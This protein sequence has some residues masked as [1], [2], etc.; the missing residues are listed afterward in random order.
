MILAVAFFA[1][2]VN[3]QTAPAKQE[4]PKKEEKKEM[5]KEEKKEMKKEKRQKKREE[6]LAKA[7]K[8]WDMDDEPGG[9]DIGF[10]GL[11]SYGKFQKKSFGGLFSK[12]K[13]S[14]A[15][16]SSLQ[17]QGD[18]PYASEDRKMS[19]PKSPRIDPAVATISRLEGEIK[20][21][22]GE[23]QK[24]EAVTNTEIA[25]LTTELAGLDGKKETLKET[26]DLAISATVPPQVKDPSGSVELVDY[27]K[28][29]GMLDQKF[30]KLDEDSALGA[31]IVS[32]SDTWT[33]KFQKGLL[34]PAEEVTVLA[35]QQVIEKNKAFDLLD[36]LTK[37]G[38]MPVA[39]GSLHVVLAATHS[40]DKQIMDTLVQDNINPIEKVERS[41]L[42]V[43]TTI[44]GRSV[45]DLVVDSEYERVK[46]Y[47]PL[48]CEQQLAIQ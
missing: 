11:S 39:D 41:T 23:I 4:A 28:V 18:V 2:T 32:A 42:I 5:K 31:T 37:S 40:F 7:K 16:S 46:T 34:S 44:H 10:I 20:T 3:A 30:E 48:V 38:V 12:S 36:A 35:P 19:A 13:P 24:L 45:Q 21:Q 25:K 6:P 1:V 14:M 26:L 43:A 8:S 29:P 47:S 15:R 33:K 17:Y 9:K 22:D 27:T